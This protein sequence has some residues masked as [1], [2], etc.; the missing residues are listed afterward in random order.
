MWILPNITFYAVL[1]SRAGGKYIQLIYQGN[2]GQ[3][4]MADMIMVLCKVQDRGESLALSH[5]QKLTGMRLYACGLSKGACPPLH[6]FD[7]PFF[8]SFPPLCCKL[9]KPCTL[10]LLLYALPP[11][12]TRVFQHIPEQKLTAHQS[13][14]IPPVQKCNRSSSFSSLSANFEKSL[15]GSDIINNALGSVTIIYLYA[16]YQAV[17]A[18]GCIYPQDTVYINLVQFMIHKQI[19]GMQINGIVHKGPEFSIYKI[20]CPKS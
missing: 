12:A 4:P 7:Y 8:P 10:Q 16:W 2:F 15:V 20:L 11:Y 9:I 13:N 6:Y 3:Y 18:F 5:F 1:V 19:N 17:S 14:I